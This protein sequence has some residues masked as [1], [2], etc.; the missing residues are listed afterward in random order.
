M[1]L[2]F[3]ALFAAGCGRQETP[4]TS[5][6]RLVV[7]SPGLVATLVDLGAA[8]S[9]VGRHAYDMALDTSIPICG[10]Q[11]G[12]DYEKLLTLHPTHVLLEWGER[13]LP[14]RLVSLADDRGWE[15]VNYR[16]RTLDELIDTSDDLARRFSPDRQPPS[17]RFAEALRREPG[18][19]AL[20][21]VLLL[22]SVDPP[23]V[24]GPGSFHHDILV[25]LGGIP[26]IG[27]DHPMAAMWIELDAEDVL[28][29][30]PGAIVLIRPR[31]G[32]SSG[33][34][35]RTPARGPKPGELGAI[36]RLPIRAVELGRLG[37]IEQPLSLT[38]STAMIDLAD[39]LRATLRAWADGE[40]R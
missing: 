33:A 18:L 9:I 12:V 3:V 22:A 5:G 29:L 40:D 28:T 39:E 32:T 27:N 10:D 20:G 4:E 21:P 26:A 30:D 23:S 15:L 11:S 37:V 35:P 6:D 7:L 8:D 16:L 2:V 34:D 31:P 19:E 17:A 14:E 36:G 13:P 24:V 1:L 38:P 25:R